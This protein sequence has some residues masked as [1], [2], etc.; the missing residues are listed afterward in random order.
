MKFRI[1]QRADYVMG[2]LRYGHR[3]GV[4]EANSLKEVCEKL[5]D[6]YFVDDLELIVDDYEVED[7]GYGTNPFQVEPMEEA[8]QTQTPFVEAQEVDEEAA[9]EVAPFDRF[10]EK[11]SAK[12]EKKIPDAE[13]LRGRGVVMVGNRWAHLSQ[14]YHLYRF[15]VERNKRKPLKRVVRELAEDDWLWSAA[16]EPEENEEETYE[17]ERE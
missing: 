12:L 3:E 4:V 1:T 9:Q 17:E 16:M 10:V 5:Q 8:E 6:G 7:V 2:H 15:Y 14:L 13:I 11:L